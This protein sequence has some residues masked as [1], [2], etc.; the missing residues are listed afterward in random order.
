M[1]PGINKRKLTRDTNSIIATQKKMNTP[2]NSIMNI[3]KSASKSNLKTPSTDGSYNMLNKNQSAP[4]K[5]F[6]NKKDSLSFLRQ[7]GTSKPVGSNIMSSNAGNLKDRFVIPPFKPKAKIS[8]SVTDQKQSESI[9]K[10]TN[11]KLLAIPEIPPF[12]KSKSRREKEFRLEMTETQSKDEKED[13]IKI[14]II[15][16]AD[17]TPPSKPVLMSTSDRLNRQNNKLTLY[18]NTQGNKNLSVIQEQEEQKDF[19]DYVPDKLKMFSPY[20]NNLVISNT[21]KVLFYERLSLGI[22]ILENDTKTYDKKSCSTIIFD[23]K[24]YSITKD[25]KDRYFIFL[26]MSAYNDSILQYLSDKNKRP[27]NK[28]DWIKLKNGKNFYVITTESN[29]KISLSY[30]ER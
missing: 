13:P 10:K 29:E 7:L 28:K 2:I 15:K 21:I 4:I 26:Q 14:N 3:R 16:P 5:K 30:F 20:L 24:L 11:D 22:E 12:K 25:D 17:A 8:E 1:T 9:L 19:K 6:E 27:S 23:N 18:K